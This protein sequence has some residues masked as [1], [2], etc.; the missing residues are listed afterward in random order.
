MIFVRGT[1]AISVET[2]IKSD[3]LISNIVRDFCIKSLNKTDC[4]VCMPK[5]LYKSKQ[6][7]KSIKEKLQSDEVPS[8]V[9]PGY[10]NWIKNIIEPM[11]KEDLALEVENKNAKN[12][13]NISGNVDNFIRGAVY[14][15]ADSDHIFINDKNNANNMI[16]KT[17]NAGPATSIL[18]NSNFLIIS[19]SLKNQITSLFKA[20]AFVPEKIIDCEEVPTSDKLEGQSSES[21]ESI[22]LALATFQ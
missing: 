14:I 10:S 3:N 17:T 15:I 18:F 21:F 7:L 8:D 20:S 19:L 11:I 16:E 2:I 4:V 22:H 13:I 9:S 5:F 6:S 12:M 1:D